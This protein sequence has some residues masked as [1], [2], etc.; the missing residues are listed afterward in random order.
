[1]TGTESIWHEY[2]WVRVAAK[3]P[4][5]EKS[6]CT[7]LHP[8]ALMENSRLWDH[9]LP[10]SE[11]D[12]DSLIEEIGDDWGLEVTFSAGEAREA[13]A[14]RKKMDLPYLSPG[15]VSCFSGGEELDDLE[16]GLRMWA[17]GAVSTLRG[18]LG[19]LEDRPGGGVMLAPGRGLRVWLVGGEEVAEGLDMEIGTGYAAYIVAERA[20]DVTDAAE[21]VLAEAERGVV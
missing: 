15:G 14:A 17:E 2:T 8:A 12:F 4:I 1:M 13:F 21:R 11:Q 18:V 20:L 19:L 16:E 5:G 3:N 10:D 7:W 6:Y 9:G